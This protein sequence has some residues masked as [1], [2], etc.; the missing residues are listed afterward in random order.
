MTLIAG[1]KSTSVPIT[2]ILNPDD[3]NHYFQL[4]HTDP[5]YSAPQVSIP[6]ENR[7]PVTSGC[8][9]QKFLLNLK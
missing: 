6:K 8:T 4:I 3:I 9:V 2:C 7:I 1:W 5:N